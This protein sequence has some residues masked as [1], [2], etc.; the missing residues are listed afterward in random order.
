MTH[1]PGFYALLSR[2]ESIDK[3]SELGFCICNDTR[4]MVNYRQAALLSVTEGLPPRLVAHSGLSTLDRNTPYA[5]WLVQL[6][7]HLAPRLQTLPDAAPVLPLTAEM[8]DPELAADWQE[9]LPP[10]V[11]IIALR[12][13][14]KQTHALLLLARDEPWPTSLNIDSAEYSLLQLCAAYGYAWWSLAVR[15]NGPR[16]WFSRH[17]K[18][19][20]LVILGVMLIAL[21][22]PVRDYTLVP[23][24]IISLHSDVIAAPSEGVLQQILIQPNTAVKKGDILARLD[25][26]TLQNR[27]AV[28]TAELQTADVTL[29]QASQQAIEDQ[30]AKADLAMAMGKM[31]EKQVEVDS[32]KRELAKLTIRSPA[33]GVFVYSDPDDWAGRPVQTGERIGLLADPATL[34]IRG[35][36]PVAESVNLRAGAPMTVFLK[37]AP[38]QPLEGTLRWAGYKATEA[39]NGIASYQLRGTLNQDGGNVARI[40][41]QGTARVAGEWRPLGYLLLRRPLATLRAWSGV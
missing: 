23:A 6:C 39:P 1:L 16:R 21:C 34:G 18:R 17:K 19:T 32:L 10:H 7:K 14:D 26:T 28:A 37:V 40:G 33:D 27:L 25:D 29:H 11:W 38:L 20:L 8:L 41:L 5:L 2:I 9:W 22:I 36:A 31:R 24:E 4:Q 13:P 12:G 30:S 3:S 15:T 35:W